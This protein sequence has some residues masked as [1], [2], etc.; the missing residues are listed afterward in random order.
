MKILYI[1]HFGQ[2]TG[3]GRA[4]HDYLMALAPHA[5]LNILPLGKDLHQ[6]EGRYRPLLERTHHLAG[7]DDAIAN[8]LQAMAP[9]ADVVVW[10][11]KPS[12]LRDY[13]KVIRDLDHQDVTQVALTT[14]EISRAPSFDFIPGVLDGLIVP[15]T[16]VRDALEDLPFPIAVVPHCFDPSFW[17]FPSE[18][19]W[20]PLERSRRFYTVGAW[21]ARKNPEGVIKAWLH[22]FTPDDGVELVIQ[23]T[24]IDMTAVNSLVGRSGLST[25]QIAPISISRDPLD[26]VE[27]RALHRSGDVYVSAHR[28]E[29]WGLGLFEAA[30]MGSFVISPIWSGESDFLLPVQ[31]TGRVYRVSGHVEPVFGGERRGQVRQVAPGKFAQESRIDLPAGISCRDVWFEPSIMSIAAGMRAH[32]EAGGFLRPTSYTHARDARNILER[33]Y[34]YEAVGP[35]LLTELKGFTQ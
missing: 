15:S 7:S 16:F 12:V 9:E 18:S 6:L 34:S 2:L 5:E 23:S 1:C 13:A 10:H 8:T 19:N 20:R 35:Q 27:L 25:D 11:T 28:G 24:D 22:A 32:L 26:E 3:Y 33:L 17:S 31:D 4:A 29:G 30:L 21:N 14:W